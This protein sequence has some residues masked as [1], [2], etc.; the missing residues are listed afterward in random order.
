MSQASNQ[1]F[2]WFAAFLLIVSTQLAGCGYGEVNG[3]TYDCAKALYSVC[4]LRD[5]SRLAEVS[6]HIESLL[7]DEKISTTEAKWLRSIIEQAKSG[8]WS[9][10]AIEARRLMTDQVEH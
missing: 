5:E 10:A 9:D 1:R 2:R 6:N 8:H 3:E 4:N 7:A